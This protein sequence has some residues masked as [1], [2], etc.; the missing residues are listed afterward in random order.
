MEKL[1]RILFSALLLSL[2]IF[3]TF[4]YDAE[5]DGIRYNLI[6]K[7]NIAE[8]SSYE[9]QYSGTIIIP[10]SIDVNG[11]V[12]SVTSIGAGAF[13]QCFELENVIMP[14]SI[15]SIGVD[16]FFGCPKL[17][18]IIIPNSVTVI[19][20]SAFEQCTTLFSIV[21]PNSLSSIEDRLFSGCSMLSSITIPENVISIGT[22]AFYGCSSLTELFIPEKVTEIGSYAFGK[23]SG[24]SEINIPN[25]VILIEQGAFAGCTGLKDVTISNSLDVI[26]GWL[27]YG[28]SSLSSITIPDNIYSILANAFDGCSRLKTLY[29]GS[30]LTYISNESFANCLELQ[31]IYCNSSVVPSIY[32]NTFDNSYANYATLHVNSNLIDSYKSNSYWEIFKEIVAL[33]ESEILKKCTPPIFTWKDGRLIIKSVTEN[34]ICHYSYSDSGIVNENGFLPTLTITAYAT[35]EGYIKSETVTYNLEIGQKDFDINSNG[36]VSIGDVTSLVNIILQKK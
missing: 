6:Q 34:A 31:D 17:S 7:A 22:N 11:I 27:F 4:A 19:G 33:N 21:L 2:P 16:A 10:Q 29:L 18:S 30:S 20:K 24:L 36:E 13:N 12:Y 8:V 32:P 3:E 5:V 35:A 14:N 9:Q 15:T 25:S 26:K 28:C 23:C 1:Y